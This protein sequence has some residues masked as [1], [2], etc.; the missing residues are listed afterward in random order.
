M[1]CR[2]VCGWTQHYTTLCHARATLK[3][4][5]LRSYWPL[6]LT[7]CPCF[8]LRTHLRDSWVRLRPGDLSL[9]DFASVHCTRGTLKNTH[10]QSSWRRLF[11][12]ILGQ[13]YSSK[14][15]GVFPLLKRCQFCARLKEFRYKDIRIFGI[16]IFTSL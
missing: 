5:I 2:T 7:F 3:L 10:T 8:F 11:C 12:G 14:H 15:A 6:I 1:Y 4:P 13:W 9:F 16:T